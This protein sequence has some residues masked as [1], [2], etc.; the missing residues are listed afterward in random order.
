MSSR[1]LPRRLLHLMVLMALLSALAPPAGAPVALATHTPP[2]TSVTIAGSFQ[3]EL[4]CGGD[5]DPACAATH[6]TYDPADDVWQGTWTVPAGAWEYKA[7]LN[8]SWAENYGLHAQQNGPNIPLSLAAPTSV[9]FY[10]DH[11][12]H[13]ITDKVNSVIAVVPGSFQSELGCGGDW[14]PGCLRSW[15]QDI[16]GDGIYTF[17]TSALPAGTYEAK[18]AI[19]ES[20][21]ENYGQNGEPN[22]PNIPFTVPADNVNVTFTYNAVSHVLTIRSMPGHDNDVWWDGLGHDS[23]DALYRAPGGAVTTGTPVL[24]RFRTYHNDVTNVTVRVWNTRLNAQQLYPMQLV[25]T[26]PD[27]PYGYDIWQ[28]TLPAQPEPTILWYRFIV[29]DGADIDY[30]EDDDLFDGGRGRP[31]DDSPDYS[32]Q[33]DVY[34]PDFETPDWMKDAV[35]YQIFPDRFRNGTRGFEPRPSDPTVYDNPVLVKLW[36]DLPEGYCRNYTNW[37]CTEGPLGRDFFG[38]DLVGIIRSLD[39]L[40]SLGVTAL[41]LNPIFKAPSNHLYDTTDYSQIDPYFGNN[42][43]FRALV[44]SARARGIRVILDGVFNHTSSDSIYF[45][46]YHRYPTLGACESEA[47]PYRAWYTF[48]PATDPNNPGPCAGGPYGSFY[49]SWFGF[50]SLPVLTEIQ[51]VRDFIYGNDDSIARRWLEMGASGWRL[52]VANE[53]SHDW[54]Q[55][56]RPR[57]KDVAPDSILIGELWGDASDWL[58]GNE[59]DTTMNYRFRRALIGFING[60]TPDPDGFIRGLT[61]SQFASTLQGIQ[62]DYPAP[63]FYAAM[64]LVD[65]HDTQRILWTLTPGQNNRTDKE[66]NTANLAEGKAKLRLLAITQFTL[67]GA[68]T[69]F[70]GDEVGVTGDD[71]PDDR[72]TFPWG[73][74]DHVLQAHYRQLAQVRAAHPALRTGSFDVILTDDANGVLVYGR[75]LC[76]DAAIV[77]LDKDTTAQDVSFNLSGYIPAGAVLTEALTGATIT[78]GPDGQVTLPGFAGRSGAIYVVLEGTDLTPPDPPTGLAATAAT[79]Q[80]SLTWNAVADAAGYNVYRS[81]VTGGGYVKLNTMPIVGTSYMDTTVVNG[82]RYYYVV[83][84]VDAVGNESGWS[85]EADALPALVIGWAN[86]QWP[87]AIT[88]VISATNPTPWIYGQVWIDGYTNLPGPTPGLWAQV[89]YGPDGSNPDGNP[90]WTWVE[91]A[92]NV[93]VG[94]NDEFKGQLLPE[95]VGVFDYAVRY[96]TTNGLVWL[97]ADLDGTGNGY[98]PD[99]AGHLEVLPS[100]DPTPPTAPQNLRVTFASPSAIGLAWDAVSDPDLFRYEIFRSGTSGGPYTKIAHVPAGTTEY[101]DLTVASGQ[102][103]YYV[104]TAQDASFN[105]SAYSNEVGQTAAPR[106][107]QVTFNVTLPAY[108]PTGDTIY[109]GANFNGWNPAGTAMTRLDPT[110]ATVTLT[111]LEG[112]RLE[113]KYTRGSWNSVE[114]GPNC[115]ELPNRVLNVIYGVNGTLT[116]ED[117][118]AKWRDI[119]NCG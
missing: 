109:I 2:P 115:E 3:S 112:E 44:L 110:H 26:T 54:W 95:M 39:Y 80:V 35:V 86:L 114:K 117:T 32:W 33:I 18:V 90:A 93:D 36:G 49:N 59:L 91:M 5:W 45:D 118:V 14:D 52:D 9:K 84:A 106:Q 41:Y 15:L 73:S 11:K 68:P 34:L 42:A 8:D 102:T 20:W 46:R 70:Y 104:V 62:E 85:N 107:V 69:I 119:D 94:N 88:H 108:T 28:A 100:G 92:F 24:L 60:D 38:G 78:V 82:T 83:T 89:G 21:D 25:A 97:Y 96:T 81:Y 105:R 6:L 58:L 17:E 22:G 48:T 74:E 87:P 12:S 113:Y 19:N 30:Y 77:V 56:F 53:K 16:D 111:F 27:A 50:D 64:N 71:D 13:W 98:S 57:V 79:S 99:Q 31:Y 103:Y 23:R 75:K 47:S 4:G 63:A 51:P 29:Q 10:Y 55:E 66:F 37:T 7:A 1:L 40:H 43:L 67:P 116:V 101:T 76:N 61:P 72:R 65:S